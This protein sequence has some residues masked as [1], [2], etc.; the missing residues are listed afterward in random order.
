M[1]EGGS[2]GNMPL[3]TML[4]LTN[5]II[6]IHHQAV[7]NSTQLIFCKVPHN[8]P[9]L[10]ILLLTHAFTSEL[11]VDILLLIHIGDNSNYPCHINQTHYWKSWLTGNH[12]NLESKEK[13]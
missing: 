2:L 1:R 8:V 11:L 13:S 3:N 6:V 4:Y 7:M 5:I 10:R 12:R 9:G